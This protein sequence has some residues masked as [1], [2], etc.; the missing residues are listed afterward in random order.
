MVFL[1]I[2]FKMR[3]NEIHIVFFFLK[4]D[5]FDSKELFDSIE[6]FLNS[7]ENLTSFK[8]Q[9]SNFFFVCRFF[10]KFIKLNIFFF[11]GKG[12]NFL[13]CLIP[14]SFFIVFQ[15]NCF[16]KTLDLSSNFGLNLNF[17]FN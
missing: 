11:V 6:N 8:L 1:F 4:K 15:K 5:V 12:I 16:L 9:L 13:K 10:I 3:K 7:N 14:S 17:N 2:I